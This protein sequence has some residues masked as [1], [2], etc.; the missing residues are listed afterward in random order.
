M[1]RVV[2]RLCMLGVV[3]FAAA[4][5]YITL[6]GRTPAAPS[7]QLDVRDHHAA[8]RAS[9]ASRPLDKDFKAAMERDSATASRSSDVAPR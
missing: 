9:T 6:R 8:M 1:T 4:A 3:A 7:T 2:R 5:I